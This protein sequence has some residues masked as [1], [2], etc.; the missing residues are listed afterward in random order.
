MFNKKVIV[1]ITGAS[2]AV[3]AVSLLRELSKRGFVIDGV[4][5]RLGKEV[6]QFESGLSESDFPFV[7]W[8]ESENMFAP[9]ASGSNRSDAMII[10]PCS[11]NTLS[12][13]AC[14]ISNN[15]LQRAALVTLKERRKLVVVPRETPLSVIHIEAMLKLAQASATILPASPGFYKKPQNIQDL[16]DFITD[17]IISIITETDTPFTPEN[18]LSQS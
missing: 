13:V 10:V 8:Y 16:T 5:S 18:S 7:N 14:G 9:I 3:Y 17:R 12:S 11:M 6:L 15:L 1:G 2:G 4:C